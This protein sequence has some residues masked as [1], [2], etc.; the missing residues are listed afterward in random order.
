MKEDAKAPPAEL[1]APKAEGA[2][3]GAKEG[4]AAKEGAKEGEAAKEGEEGAKEE[5]PK[6]PPREK[7]IYEKAGVHHFERGHKIYGHPVFKQMMDKYLPYHADQDDGVK[8]VYGWH[9]IHPIEYNDW[10]NDQVHGAMTATE[11]YYPMKEDEDERKWAELT[12][13]SEHNKANALDRAKVAFEAAEQ[14]RKAAEEAAGAAEGEAAAGDAAGTKA[15]DG[16]APAGEEGKKEEAKAALS[17][18]TAFNDAATFNI[19]A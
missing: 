10:D 3:E 14:A 8:W 2:K 1:Q 17:Q 6:P 16:A 19:L 5:A 11:G 15:A 12:N 13:A 7:N 4:E 9:E 18:Q